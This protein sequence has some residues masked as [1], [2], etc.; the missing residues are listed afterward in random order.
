MKKKINNDKH[1]KNYYSTNISSIVNKRYKILSIILSIFFIFLIISLFYVQIIDGNRYKYKLSLI[2]EV[3]IDGSS[4]AR[5]RIYD[6]NGNVIVDNQAVKT[7][8][9]KKKI[10]ITKKEEVTLAYNAAELLEIDYKKLNNYDLRNFWVINNSHSARNKITEEEWTLYEE[11]KLSLDD[12]E[13]LKRDR[14]TEEEL[15]EYKAIDREAA[16]IYY[17]MNKGYSYQE[18]VIKDEDV[19][20]EEYALVAANKE[21]LN[22]F[23]NKLDWNRHY[24]YGDTMRSI[25][26]N[27]SSSS[28]G[29]P[30]ENKESYLALGYSLNDRVGTS[31]LEYQYE[32]ILKGTKN[33]YILG[34]NGEYILK[35][36]GS[37]GNDIVL[38]ID[39]KLQKEIEKIVIDELIKAKTK[40]KHTKYFD[41]AFVIVSNPKTGEILAMVGKVIKKE[42]GKWKIYDYSNGIISESITPGSSVKAASHMVGYMTGNLKIGEYRNDACIKIAATP[43]KCSYTRYGN[44]NDVQALKYSSNT[45]Q[46]QTAIKVGKG[47]YKY[48]GPLKLNDSAF[49]TYRDIFSQFGLGVK[50]GIDLPNEQLGYTGTSKQAGL[51]LDYSIGQYDNYTPIQMSQYINTVANDGMR[52]KPFLLKEVYSPTKDGLTSL[53]YTNSPIMLNQI[54][55][56][57][58]YF[59]RIKKGLQEVIKSGTGYGFIDN[60]YKAAGKT[61]TSESFIDTNNDGKIDKETLSTSLVAYAP[62]DNPKVTFTVITPNIGTGNISFNQIS[63][64]NKRIS[65]KISKKYFE[66]YK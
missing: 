38:T 11:R 28:N 3:V 1:Y 16:Y 31:Y 45:Y 20:D 33:K 26:G 5:G 65:R 37:R 14:V 58:K 17:L 46:F 30:Y 53:I 13:K 50:T 6:R 24:V 47:K 32:S 48:N 61:G 21:E 22:G 63:T 49:D 57:K 42:D 9:Y 59:S 25:L 52:M 15:N 62:Y 10:G 18:K 51:L 55:A 60:K 43:L 66:I 8:Y 34:S 36:E 35:E 39:I 23:I 4:P 12:I 40:D 7:I 56:E 27:V 54:N 64:I 29:I 44:I 2:N 41:R 19:T